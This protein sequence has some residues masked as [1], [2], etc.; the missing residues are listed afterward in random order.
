MAFDVPTP[1]LDLGTAAAL[2]LLLGLQRERTHA[3]FGVEGTAG[4]RTFPLTA[5]LG[6]LAGLAG[7]GGGGGIASP[8]IPAAG[9]A[10]VGLLVLAAYRRE[11]RSQHGVGLTGEILL[12]LTYVLGVACV[13]GLRLEAAVTG[14]AALLLAGSKDR[15][16]GF[17]GRLTDADEAAALKFLAIAL[18]VLPL[19]PDHDFGPFDSF[20]PRDVGWMAVLVAGI[21]FIGFV[22]V[23]VVGPGR[24]LLVTGILGGLASSTATTAAFARRSREAPELSPSL[25]AGAVAA[26]AVLFLRLLILVQI[27]APAFL[28]SSAPVL[29]GMFLVAAAAAALGI[30]ALRRAPR[31]DVP[32]KNPFELAPALWFAGAYAVVVMGARAASA[33]FGNAGLYV[34]GAVSGTTDVDAITL[35]TARLSKTG[36][37]PAVLVRVIVLAIVSNSIVKTGIAFTLGSKAYAVRMAAALGATAAAGCVALLFL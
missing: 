21:S 34:A 16:H 20:N 37:D 33:W 27:A 2:G 35:T 9:L 31:V 32:L 4:A 5:L 7:G 15:L 6:G 26:C 11:S 36:T 12:L 8:W 3:R 25:A 23:K 17:A 22:A 30:L 24:G 14:A 29:G 28:P 18:I 1:I 13:A 19:L 10:V